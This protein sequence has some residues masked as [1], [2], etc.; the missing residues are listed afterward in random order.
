MADQVYKILVV[1]DEPDAREIFLDILKTVENYEVSSAADGNDALA[2]S[3]ATKFDLIL[4]D[5]VMPSKDGV[6]TLSE[7]KA[8]PDKYGTPKV[9]MLTN[10]GGDLAIEEALKLGAMGYRLKIETEPEELLKAVEQ[11]LANDTLQAPGTAV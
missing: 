6:Q 7:I 2:K 3:E 8:N 5:I 9:I 11:A 4:L 10:I 1:D